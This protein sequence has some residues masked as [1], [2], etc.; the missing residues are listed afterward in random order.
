[1]AFNE[2]KNILNIL[3]SIDEQELDNVLIDEIIIVLGGCTDDTYSKVKSYK[4]QYSKKLKIINLKER[5]GKYK[6]VN[7]FLEKAKSEILVLVSA[8]VILNK[9]AV[10]NIIKPFGDKEI[11]IVSSR[12]IPKNVNKN[13]ITKIGK[14]IWD[15]HHEISK[16][17]PK[18]GEFIAF[19]NVIEK[20]SPSSTDEE[21]IAEEILKKEYIP[22]YAQNSI[23]YN[24]VP[25]DFEDILISRRRLHC[26]HLEIKSRGYISSSLRYGNILF[27]FLKSFRNHPAHIIIL[28]VLIEIY[29]RFFGR[30]DF[31]FNKEK[32][33]VW[34]MTKSTK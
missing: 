34:K 17:K 12:V 3:N 6:D 31:M 8:D 14:F 13:L 2:E 25:D 18:F 28:A 4:G 26:G 23:A 7:L 32:H 33:Y 9:N 20:I 19:R 24:K 11:G 22:F 1:M 15:I 10:E 29:S 27:A 5:R 21:A 16:L 30:L